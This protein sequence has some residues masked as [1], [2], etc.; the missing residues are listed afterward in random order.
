MVAHTCILL[1]SF[2]PPP[3]DSGS[4]GEV[5][6]TAESHLTFTD[7]TRAPTAKLGGQ[8][9]LMQT[10]GPQL[11]LPVV[12]RSLPYPLCAP[13]SSSLKQGN[14]S[15]CSTSCCERQWRRSMWNM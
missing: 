15:A 10:L 12:L 3:R 11:T 1:I 2:H 14:K 13:V 6:D 4:P 7:A 8:D 5:R 9:N